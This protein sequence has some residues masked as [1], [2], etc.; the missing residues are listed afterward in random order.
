MWGE[1]TPKITF[2][3]V[4][5]NESFLTPIPAKQ[6]LGPWFKKIPQFINGDKELK[7]SNGSINKTIKHCIPVLDAMT[8]GYTIPLVGEIMVSKPTEEEYLFNWMNVHPLVSTHSKSQVENFQFPPGYSTTT[9]FKWHSRF[10]VQTPPGYS[11][12]FMHPVNRWD[13]PFYSL[14]GIVD[15]D[16]HPVIINFPFLVK[17]GFSGKIEMGTPLIQL[18]PFKREKWNSEI[19]PGSEKEYTSVY[20][21]FRTAIDSKY[22][23]DYW[24]R[25]DYY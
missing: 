13:L 10:L 1:K 16:K 20:E 22:K 9:A 24:S 11:V 25:K 17:E 15:T 18:F 4:D 19:L 21:A 8:S 7:L 3:R 6:T 14:P 23:N 12:F 2:K 5:E